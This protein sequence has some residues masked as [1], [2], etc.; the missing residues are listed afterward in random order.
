MIMRVTGELNNV[1]SKWKSEFNMYVCFINSD[2]YTV[3]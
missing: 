1:M 3:E 2:N